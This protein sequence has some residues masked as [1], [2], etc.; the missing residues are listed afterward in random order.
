MAWSSTWKEDK[1]LSID[2]EAW[3]AHF[4]SKAINRTDNKLLITNFLGSDQ[5]SDLTIP[6]NCRGFGRIRHFHR[7]HG[8]WLRNPLPLDPACKALGMQYADSMQAQVFQVAVCNWRCWYCYVPFDLLSADPRHSSWLSPSDLLDLYLSEPNP[9]PI[10]D[11]TGG[12][13]DLV[14]EWIPWM[15]KEVTNR[16]L[17][18]KVYL[19]SDDNLSND[20][21]WR[22]LSDGD[23]EVLAHYPYYGR[24]CCFKGYDAESFAFNTNAPPELFELQFQLMQRLLTV[25]MDIYAYTTF[26]GPNALK[27]RESVRSFVDR[28]QELDE[29]LP[30]RT[31]PLQIHEFTPVTRRMNGDRTRSL[32]VQLIAAEA[33]QREVEDRFS[34]ELRNL[35]IADVPL[36]NRR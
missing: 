15:I 18:G 27:V 14:P 4:R 3:S 6:P 29:Y 22:F 31:V 7:D 20:Y 26:T 8:D 11:L 24:V 28:L 36:R 17:D 5:Q 2:T 9:P 30:L 1:G 16:G 23:R 13:P 34:S 10:L 33:W 35:S 19:W 25:G 32:D 12:Q 21:F